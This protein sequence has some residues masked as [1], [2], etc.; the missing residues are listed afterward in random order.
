MT[1]K[2]F[3]VVKKRKILIYNSTFVYP[4]VINDGQGSYIEDIDEE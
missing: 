2:S 1:K 3:S 4:L